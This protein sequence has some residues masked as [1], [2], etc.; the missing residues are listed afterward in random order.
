MGKTT[1]ISLTSDGCDLYGELLEPMQSD[2]IALI[3]AGYGPIDRNGNQ[4]NG[5]NNCL[6]L[7]AEALCSMGCASI[8]Y[9][10]RG[11]GASSFHGLTESE[12]SFD[13]YVHDAQNWVRY[14]AARLTHYQH[15]MLI[16]VGE[17]ALITSSIANMPCVNNMI[18]IA[19]SSL[20]RQKLLR[21]QLSSLPAPFST[22]ALDILDT[23]AA[24][25]P[26]DNV[27]ES[28]NHLFRPSFQPYLRSLFRYEPVDIIAR[29]SA[30]ILLIYGDHDLELG[31]LNGLALEAAQPNA[32]YCVIKG[33]NHVLKTVGEDY[34]SNRAAYDN[35]HQPLSLEL[36]RE[37][38]RF[39]RVTAP[40]RDLHG[41]GGLHH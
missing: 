19:A 28:L 17:G 2:T 23:L 7:L 13:D 5:K 35:P 8:R 15:I 12:L 37:I 18:M 40:Q 38:R 27:P 30:P 6:K 29:V 9:D 1:Q 22:E 25:K 24:N 4:P 39:I 36:L 41:R 20:N 31:E 16:G 26:V 10:K 11:V 21:L 32:R 14:I 34:D 3:V 33:M